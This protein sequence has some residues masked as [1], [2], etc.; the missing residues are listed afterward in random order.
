[1]ITPIKN[2][3]T[4]PLAEGLNNEKQFGLYWRLLKTGKHS[5]IEEIRAIISILILELSTTV[6][7]DN[8]VAWENHHTNN[9]E[10]LRLISYLYPTK[11]TILLI[12]Y[13]QTSNCWWGC[14]FKICSF[15]DWI[16]PNSH[17]PT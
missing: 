17:K 3:Q 1:L 15:G 2:Q 5:M 14:I 16:G 12:L 13:L 6:R 9:C 4:W 7:K 10:N 11:H 8:Q